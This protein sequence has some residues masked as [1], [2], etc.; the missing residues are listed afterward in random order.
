MFYCA[1]TGTV[2][3]Q[4]GVSVSS[5]TISLFNPYGSGKNLVL[6]DVG[7]AVFASPAAAAQFSLAY[8][9]NA[10]Q[11]STNTGVAG[12]TTTASVSRS[13]TAVVAPSGICW[14]QGI[15]SSKPINFRFIGG[16]TGASA[17]SGVVF[18]DQTQGKVVVPPGGL[19]SLQSS[20]A[21]TLEAHFLWREDNL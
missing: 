2:V 15:L 8:S 12:S 13:T 10:V 20:S 6:L 16:V 5:P 1:S 3:T 11:I 7:V 4:A 19:I 17:I 14:L 21:A 18:T 9:T